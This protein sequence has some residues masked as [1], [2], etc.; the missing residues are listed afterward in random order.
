MESTDR[1]DRPMTDREHPGVNTVKPTEFDQAR[2]RGVGLT[3]GPK[4]RA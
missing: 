2:D 3:Q 4:L 1:A